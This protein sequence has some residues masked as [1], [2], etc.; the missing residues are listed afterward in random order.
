MSIP[1]ITAPVEVGS[2][3]FRAKEQLQLRG[4]FKTKESLGSMKHC[5][6][7]PKPKGNKNLSEY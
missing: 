2:I 6:R 7:K 5:L 1:V 3:V 4:S